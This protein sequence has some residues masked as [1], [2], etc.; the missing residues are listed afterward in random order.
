MF[1][2]RKKSETN[3][4]TKAYLAARLLEIK[5]ILGPAYQL[6]SVLEDVEIN[7]L[8]IGK[9]EFGAT[10]QVRDRDTTTSDN[11]II[12]LNRSI[13]KVKKV[14]WVEIEITGHDIDGD[15]RSLQFQLASE[16][17]EAFLT[18]CNNAPLHETPI[19]QLILV[20]LLS[21]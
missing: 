21:Q 12:W 6:L 13:H 1:F 8:T 10:I 17:G 11:V 20:Q 2:N 5:K 3:E 4:P 14:S 15:Y 9:D 7:L 18:I 16:L 19:D